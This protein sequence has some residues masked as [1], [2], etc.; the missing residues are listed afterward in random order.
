MLLDR[1]IVKGN[2]I[3]EPGLFGKTVYVIKGNEIKEP[4]FLGKTV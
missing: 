4:G 3:K 2:E 1:L